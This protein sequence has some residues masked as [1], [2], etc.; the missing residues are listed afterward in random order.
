[1]NNT[2]ID[3]STE[4]LKM[5]SVLKE[6]IASDSNTEI[7]IAT[8]YWDMPGVVLIYDELKS[9]L[10]RNDT[11]L[12]LLIGKEPMVRLYQQTEPRK[13]DDFPGQYI[14]TDI[15]KLQLTNEFQKAVNLIMDYCTDDFDRSKFQIK[16]YGQGEVEQFLHAKCYIFNG[17]TQ[18]YGIVGS[19]NFTKRGLEDNA[20]L[21]YL[22]TSRY[23]VN[24]QSND[25]T[26]K[27]HI[28]WFK[29]KW[30]QSVPWNQ[31][32]L[33]EILKPSPIGV[34]IEKERQKASQQL[35]PYEFYIKL[36]QDKFGS[37]ADANAQ[38]LL[39]SYLPEGFQTLDYQIE[40]VQW[41]YSIMQQHGGFILGDV[42]GLGKTIVGVMLLKYFSEFADS[43]GRSSKVLIIT[44]PAIKSTWIET[45][46]KFDDG[47]NDKMQS[48]IDFITTGSIDNLTQDSSESD[49][50][51]AESDDFSEQLTMNDYGLILIDESHK[52]RNNNT[53]MYLALEALINNIFSQK[54]YY[55]YI[56]LLSATPQNNRPDDLK[57]QIYLFQRTPKLSTFEKIEGRN[58]ESFFSNINKNYNVLI[59]QKGETPEEIKSNRT[60][61]QKI[62]NEI[63]D[64]VLADILVRRTRTD[65]KKYSNSN[66]KFPEIVGPVR[67][68]YKLDAELATLFFD[69]MNLIAPSPDFKFN[70]SD[71][72][73]YYRYRATEYLST[74]Y[75]ERYKGKNMT[76]ETSSQRLAKI[77]Q[78]LL[79]KRLESS[80]SAFKKSLQNLQRYT[81][82]MITM[83]DNNCIFVCPQIDVNAELD[84]VEKKKKNK[85]ATLQSCFQDIRN[86]IKKLDAENRNDKTQNAE[87]NV[88]DFSADYIELLKQDKAIID[89]LVKRWANNDYDPKLD[90]F[91]DSLKSEL[92]NKEKNKPQKLVIFS[93]AIDTVESLERAVKNKGFRPLL[94]TAANRK[95][96]ETVIKENFDANYS[97]TWKNDFDTIITTE[98]LA[99][100]IN[101]H[102]ANTI[103]NYDTP[104][105]AT[106]LIQRIGRVNRIGSTEDFVYVYNFYPSAEGDHEINLVQNAFVKLQSFHTLF[107]EDNQIFSEEETLS[108]AGYSH[109][110]DG[111]ETP[112]QRFIA[113]LKTYKENNTERYKQLLD[114]NENLQVAYNADT[115][116]S[117]FVI[118]TKNNDKGGLYVTLGNDFSGKVIPAI[119]MLQ[120]CRCAI[121]TPITAI[122]Q[123]HIQFEEYAL[124][125]YNAYVQKLQKSQ[126]KNKYLV[127]A[128]T[129][130]HSWINASISKQSKNLLNNAARLVKKGNMG[131]ANK[132]IKIGAQLGS[133]QQTL[134]QITQSD[135]DH[136]IT[137]EL[138]HIGEQNTKAFGEPYIFASSYKSLK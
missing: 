132:I 105:N 89:Q 92:F 47:R 109:L 136:I 20:E 37:L 16:I 12:K 73:C 31:V 7:L 67:L 103:L 62:S 49:D 88:S 4:T 13:R 51:D 115:D 106:R 95:E 87:Y 93:E 97:G 79:V 117:L 38:E 85:A 90:T 66:L 34:K 22:E 36:L 91:K 60:E 137:Q 133:P 110:L 2:L 81:Q 122:P 124:Q 114:L 56:G 46:D 59:K 86:K 82:N 126:P 32:F 50:M 41:C 99:E 77:M 39:N 61:L 128:Q 102:R 48:N 42:V 138:N 76:P 14:K 118:K 1:M 112:Y 26:I 120:K 35:T 52:F 3:N 45:I 75:K 44:P 131:V 65:V 30:E 113:E 70:N 83:W 80:F 5:V 24:Y 135:I 121:E 123:N 129:I 71:Y 57:N 78:I 68:E 72:L 15:D 23:V 84:L 134:F 55:P 130:I 21:N 104:W 101:L 100:G 17:K 53:E 18:A 11:S 27:G 58:L 125:T 94:I 63:R 119:E 69:T 98:V 8:G 127:Q 25:D 33:E 107:G 6:C 10:E 116:E 108:E 74:Q 28:G 111:D 29:E 64:K 19:S 9:F 96:K 43:E 40:A 54:G